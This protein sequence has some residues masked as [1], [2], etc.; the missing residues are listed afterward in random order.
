MNKITKLQR[1]ARWF[2]LHKMQFVSVMIYRYM[3]FM[4]SC[5]IPYTC[6]IAP[7]VNFPHNAL[8][9]VINSSSKIGENC[10]IYQNVTI[11]NRNSS[12]GPV[13]KDG[14]FVGANATI[15]GDITIGENSKIGGGALVVKSVKPG[16]TVVSAPAKEIGDGGNE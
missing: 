1:R 9:V 3:R 6:E 16:S 14:V 5:V 7:T 10:T 15:L 11:G 2:Y 8:G 4:Y 12:E 13:L